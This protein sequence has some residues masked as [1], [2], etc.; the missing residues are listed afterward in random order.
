MISFP[1]EALLFVTL[2]QGAICHHE[3]ESNQSPSPA[4]REKWRTFKQCLSGA[5]DQDLRRLMRIS[6]KTSK[7]EMARVASTLFGGK[8]N[9]PFVNTRQRELHVYT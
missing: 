6:V 5:D 2:S 3:V 9:S 7:L 4:V 8:T 1:A